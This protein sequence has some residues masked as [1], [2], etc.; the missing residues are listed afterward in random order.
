[1]PRLGTAA[2]C[3]ACRQTAEPPVQIILGPNAVDRIRFAPEAA[4]AEYIELPSGGSELRVTLAS[5]SA[6]C[7]EFVPP[8]KE[9]VLLVVVVATPRAQKLS[10]TEYFWTGHASHGGTPSHPERPYAAP[11]V[12]RGQKAYRIPPGGSI[13]LTALDLRP[14]GAVKGTLAF[15]FAGDAQVPATSITGGF[16]TDLCRVER[17]QGG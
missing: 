9:Q 12:R 8:E 11:S 1:M 16:D 17:A 5:Y 14:G 2:L 7:D 15:E 4:F 10:Q 3:I 13:R 6:R